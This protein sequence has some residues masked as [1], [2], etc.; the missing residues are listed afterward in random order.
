MRNKVIG[1]KVRDLLILKDMTVIPYP[2]QTSLIP[3][4]GVFA[5]VV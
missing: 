3:V 4:C 2:S 5:M 1:S